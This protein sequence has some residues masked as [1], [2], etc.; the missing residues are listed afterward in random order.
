MRVRR[1]RR[2]DLPNPDVDVY[3]AVGP[4]YGSLLAIRYPTNDIMQI[5][6]Y[7]K[8]R[9]SYKSSILELAD[10]YFR[11]TLNTSAL[12]RNLL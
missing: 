11:Y 3:F 12:A 2:R 7:L 10:Q 8:A 9:F 6:D 4:N 1:V 5:P